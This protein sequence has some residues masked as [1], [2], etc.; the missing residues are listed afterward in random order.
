L[1]VFRITKVLNTTTGLYA[2]TE[3]VVHAG[4]AGRV[5][6]PSMT[7]AERAQ[8]GLVPAVQDVQIHVAVGSTPDV[9]K[10]HVWRVT[11][12][13]S[14]ESLVLREFR[15]TSLPQGGQTTVHRYPVEQVI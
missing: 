14:D 8:G 5:K 13:T 10:N 6:F 1:T 4:V 12:S 7:V 3:V 15:T 9:L 2:E 11:A